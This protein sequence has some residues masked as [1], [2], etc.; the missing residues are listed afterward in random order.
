MV[1]GGHQWTA[2]TYG[3][4]KLR[5]IFCHLPQVETLFGEGVHPLM[6]PIVVLGKQASGLCSSVVYIT[7]P[8]Y[9]GGH[10]M[11]RLEQS[12]RI[13]IFLRSVFDVLFLGKFLA[14]PN[15]N[16]RVGAHF[17]SPVVF[18]VF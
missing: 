4:A 2:V 8:S 1:R 12:W 3:R 14:A 11:F 10:P 15:W 13:G 9:P 16:P 17:V 6:V 18:F 7:S 5:F